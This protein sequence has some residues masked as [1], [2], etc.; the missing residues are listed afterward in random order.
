LKKGDVVEPYEIVIVIFLGIIVLLLASL[1]FRFKIQLKRKN[2]INLVLSKYFDMGS[3]SWRHHQE[4]YQIEID[5]PK[6]TFMIKIV[7]FYF[8]YELIITNSTFWCIN[9]DPKEWRRSSKP[10][11]VPKVER[12]VSLDNTKDKPLTKVALIYPGA[13][14][15]SRYLNESDVELVNFQKPVHGIFFVRFDELSLFFEDHR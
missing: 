15:I 8:N 7:P 13:H 11:L 12:F 6:Q 10:N 2:K 3:V 1:Y 14:N 4:S 9:Q 5:T